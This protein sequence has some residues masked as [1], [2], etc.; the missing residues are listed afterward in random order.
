MICDARGV[1]GSKYLKAPRLCLDT[2]GGKSDDNHGYDTYGVIMLKG[3]PFVSGMPH[4]F[5][6]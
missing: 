1:H 4:T 2:A 3:A 6:P 5:T